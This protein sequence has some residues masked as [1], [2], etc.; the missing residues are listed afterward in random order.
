MA[1]SRIKVWVYEKLLA[2]DLNAEFNNIL[3]SALSLISPLTG[4]LDAG[5]NRIT[6]LG[7]ATARADAPNAGQVQDGAFNYGLTAGTADA[8]T[9]TLAPAITA[10]ATGM[11]FMIKVGAGLTTTSTTP[12]LNANAVGAKTL[13][14]SSGA[15]LVF[16]AALSAGAFQKLVYDGTN[17]RIMTE[18]YKVAAWTPVLTAAAGGSYTQ[19]SVGYYKRT[20]PLVQ[21]SGSVTV[22]AIVSSPSGALTIAGL[23]YTTFDSDANAAAIAL[24]FDD[25]NIDPAGA[26]YTMV[27]R[28]IKNTTTLGL[29]APVD[30][31][32]NSSAVNLIKSSSVV[33]FTGHYF[34]GAVF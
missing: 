22:T 16:G 29:F 28:V 4:N 13:V 34:T 20:G 7:N 1:L 19:T 30:N 24:Y 15:A 26:N 32:T 27:G 8:Q 18:P 10:Y 11:E 23:P 5:S 14:D 12:T 17:L 9:V 6:T 33:R 2:T 31:T 3:N 25:A 21:F